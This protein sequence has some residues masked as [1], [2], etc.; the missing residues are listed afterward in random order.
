MSAPARIA[1]VVPGDQSG[2]CGVTDYT[3]WIAAAAADSGTRVLIV[4]LH[5]LDPEAYLE[6]SS[7]EA[8]GRIAVRAPVKGRTAPD[9]VGRALAEFAPDW[10]SLQFSPSA[11]RTGKMIYPYL[12]AICT[13]LSSYPVALSVHESW[14]QVGVPRSARGVAMALFRRAEILLAWRKLKPA[15][16]FASNP[17]HVRELARAGMRPELLPIFS[18]VPAAPRPV[19]APELGSVL[20]CLA[21]PP[22]ESPALPKRALIAVFFARIRPEFDP[23]PLIARLRAEAAAQN[24]SLV[25][26]SVGETGYAGQGWQRVKAAAAGTPCVHLGRRPAPEITRLLHAADYGIS[27]TPLPFWQK[28]S[29]CAA[30]LAHGLPLIF[31]ETF[32]PGDLEL[33]ARFATLGPDRLDWH[34][35][36]NA[37]VATATTAEEIWHLIQTHVSRAL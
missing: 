31:S 12:A 32:V 21:V 34:E 18:N 35:T 26:L 25:L 4:C 8:Q 2:P 11:F 6:R 28:S 19:V 15:H 24:R 17:H 16:V 22:P 33:P 30:M 3:F 1:F 29:S 20:A 10:V 5:S 27:P 23:A 9:D 36:P 37:R 7:P 13:Q 14:T